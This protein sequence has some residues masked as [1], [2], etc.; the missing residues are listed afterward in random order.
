MKFVT[1]FIAAFALGITAAAGAFAQGRHDEKP[2]GVQ[3]PAV[4]P[5]QQVSPGGP[6]GRHDERPHGPRKPAAK[7]ADSTP[8]VDAAKK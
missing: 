6:M 1:T 3:K 7:Q 4:Q 5:G 8:P 2:H